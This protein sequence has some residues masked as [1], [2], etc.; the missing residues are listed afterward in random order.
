MHM[1]WLE[2]VITTLRKYGAVFATMLEA[3][4]LYGDVPNAQSEN[5]Y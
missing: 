5:A 1:E 2:R 4:A 3:S